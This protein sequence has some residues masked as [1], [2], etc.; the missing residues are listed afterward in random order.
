MASMDFVMD[1]A[2]ILVPVLYVIGMFLKST[3]QVPDW[4]IP[5]IM[6]ILG[7]A[8]AV[9][10]LGWSVAAVFQGILVAGAAVFAH[11]LIKQSR[12]KNCGR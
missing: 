5:W 2:L 8:G 3:P 12:H 11:Q 6:L 4:F 9:L 7:I 1:N 10:A